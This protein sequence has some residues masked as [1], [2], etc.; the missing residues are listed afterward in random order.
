[1]AVERIIGVDFGTSTSVIRVKRYE[2]GKPL[3]QKLDTK[4]VLFGGMGAMV[5]TLIQKKQ[6]DA[7]VAY[8]GF[9]AQQK[10]KKS[11]TYHSFK[12][13]LE[14]S[15]PE[16]RAQAKALTEE[17]F[18]FMGKQYRA[19]SDGGHLG[20]AGDKER[21]IISYP[22]KWSEETKQFMIAAAKKAGFPN[23]TGMD[24]AQAAIH[25]VTIMSED[26]LRKNNLLVNGK[27]SNILLIDMGAGTTDLVLCRHTPG[28]VPKTEILTTWP[29]SGEILFGGRE[30]DHLLQGFF[31]DFMEPEDL[32]RALKSIGIDQ[33]K[34]WKEESV[35]PALAKND[36]VTD[37]FALDNYADIVGIE[38]DEYRLDRAGFENCLGDY[39]KQLPDLINGCL[40]S[41]GMNGSDVD[42]VIVTGGHSQWYFVQAMLSGKMAQFGTVDLPRIKADYARII[43]ITRPQETVALG[44]VYSPMQGMASSDPIPGSAPTPKP[45]PSK[46]EPPKSAPP[47]P[48]PPKPNLPKPP[49]EEGYT[50]ESEFELLAEGEN[51]VIKKYIGKRKN[52]SIPPVIR[53]RKVVAVGEKAF[54]TGV[55]LFAPHYVESVIIPNTVTRIDSQ[56][57]FGCKKLQQIILS[58][59]VRKIGEFAFAWC[60]CL[61]RVQAHEN[62][63]IIG[64]KAFLGCKALSSVDFGEGFCGHKI[65]RFPKGLKEI[66]GSAFS[67]DTSGLGRCVLREITLSKSTKVK[68]LFGEKTFHPKHCAVFYY[69]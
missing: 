2:N 60:S 3:G 54:V 12:V 9:E 18:A 44:L 59:S 7:S 61:E 64:I 11:T 46:P 69:D 13:D 42:L 55:N 43:P 48:V 49:V 38:M 32:E 37:F 41:A 21:T 36:A 5:P 25:A 47:K 31:R 30:V 15:D 4:E 52:V 8:Y 26:H 57:F 50:P 10:R 24:E 66:G 22:V 27:A 58:D 39:L 28:A 29:K 56:A 6:D 34:S 35:S 1:M 65:V 45:E 19:Q 62:I 20:D 33:F 17:F 63:E 16:K 68:N 14:S 51:Y 53:G 67:E 23:V 40:N